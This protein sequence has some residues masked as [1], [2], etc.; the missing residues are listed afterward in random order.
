M[1]P[2][3]GPDEKAPRHLTL[4]ENP[5]DSIEVSPEGAV[6][7]AAGELALSAVV[8]TLSGTPEVLLAPNVY[9]IGDGQQI[10]NDW[11]KRKI[12]GQNRQRHFDRSLISVAS[13]GVVRALRRKHNG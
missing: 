12:D 2:E 8:E 11:F 10:S 5:T 13:Q 9:D 3:F 6:E 1:P 4:V 7:E